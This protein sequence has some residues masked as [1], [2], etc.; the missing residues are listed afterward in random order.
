MT[1]SNSANSALDDSLIFSSSW[2]LLRQTT[3]CP[4]GRVSETLYPRLSKAKRSPKPMNSVPV[5][6]CW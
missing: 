5:T 3:R 1:S 2:A 6:T 4:D